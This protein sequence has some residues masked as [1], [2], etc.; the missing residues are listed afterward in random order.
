MTT[1]E[2]INR[3]CI[4]KRDWPGAAQDIDRLLIADLEAQLRMESARSKGTVDATRTIA[5]ILKA[6]KDDAR[7]GLRYPWIDG[8]GRQCVC[9]G[10]QAFRLRKH[11][12]LIERPDN[13]GRA[14]DLDQVFPTSL[15]GW[16]ELPMPDAAEIRSFIRLER[17]KWTGRRKDFVPQWDFGPEAPTVNAEYLLNAAQVFPDA[18]KLFWNTLVSPLV[19][20]GEDGDG[21]FLPIRVAAKTQP[22]PRTEAEREAFEREKAQNEANAEAARQR[23]RAVCEAKDREHAAWEDIKDAEY[24]MVKAKSDERRALE[25]GDEEKRADA[26]RRQ[27]EADRA[28]AKAQLAHHAAILDQD[29]DEYIELDKLADIIRKLYA[30]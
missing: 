17:A 6:N 2:I 8:D 20:I 23:V 24:A 27:A 9:D 15:A 1:Q 18:G 14:I 13:A 30:A 29:R 5:A 7:E 4:I 19:V 12:P 28:W 25:A 10:F 26:V 11:L 21:L 3:L 16:K 22:A